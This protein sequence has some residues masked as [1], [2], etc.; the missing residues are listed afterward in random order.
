LNPVNL[1]KKGSSFFKINAVNADIDYTYLQDTSGVSTGFLHSI[2]STVGYNFSMNLYMA[3]M[4]FDVRL[5]GNNGIYSIY[6]TPF[7]N[8]PQFNFNHQAYLELLQKQVLSKVNPDQVLASVLTRINTIKSQYEN[9]LNSEIKKMTGEYEAEYKN[10]IALPPGITDLSVNDLSSLKTKIISQEILEEYKRSNDVYQ[11]LASGNINNSVQKD[12]LQ[13]LALAGIKKKEILDK[14]YLRV[15]NWKGKFDDNPL[16]KELRSHLPFTPGN[17]KSYL[18]KPGNLVDVIKSQASLSGLQQLF[19]NITKLDMGTNPLSG[20]QLNL[21]NVM[22]NGIS[23]EFTN[24]RSSTGFVYGSGKANT[25]DWLQSGLTSFSSNE[26]SRLT[27]IKFGSGW[28]SSMKQSISLNFFDFNSSSNLTNPDP[29]TLQ[30]GYLSTPSRRDAVITWQSSFDIAANQKISVDLSKSFGAY[31]NTLSADSTTGKSNAFADVF[32]KEG[33]SNYAVAIDYAGNLAKTDIGLS[34]KKAGL[35]YNNPG[36]IF[37]RKGE[38]SFGLNA[39]RKFLKQKLTVKYKT[40][41]SNQYF[42]PSKNYTYTNFSNSLQL[43]YKVNR[44]DH[45]G[46]TMRYN[47]YHLNDHLIST[48]P[49]QG[50]NVNIQGDG[51]YLFWIKGK[52]VI[53]N[54]IISRQSFDIPELTGEAYTSHAWLMTHSSTLLLKKNL[55]TFTLLLNRSDNKDYYFNT[56]FFNSEVNYS[57]GA[58]QQLRLSSAAGF[59][60]NTGWNKQVGL[61][62]QASGTLFKKLDIDISADWKKAIKVIRPELANQVF[63]TTTVHYRF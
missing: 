39:A 18:Q 50:K 53:N 5:A 31:R 54:F 7:N 27:G 56:S 48:I 8:F 60:S 20:G 57:Y 40:A 45:F 49:M 47:H 62:Q 63:V 26:Y 43:G 14:I 6:N 17:F 23:T 4:P 52:R 42:D 38:S 32:G 29:T 1:F 21:Q 19:L 25:N 46:M 61:R 15:A 59:Y 9:S 44:N 58:G 35:G 36:D 3:N 41:F 22:N 30:S 55:L 16:V 10:T 33:K 13:K 34:L 51:G 11:E 2:Q 37:V 12:S 28:N 24:K